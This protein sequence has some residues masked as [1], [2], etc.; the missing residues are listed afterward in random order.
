MYQGVSGHPDGRACRHLVLPGE[1]AQKIGQLR[2][3]GERTESTV[4]LA[5][6][7]N[8]SHKRNCPS[9]ERVGTYSQEFWANE[10]LGELGFSDHRLASLCLSGCLSR[11]RYVG[12]SAEDDPN[13][14]GRAEAT[15]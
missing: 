13:L 8:L 5:S 15:G 1:L 7:R 3:L 14:L 10:N 12:E 11:A 2:T 9:F 4:R 6:E